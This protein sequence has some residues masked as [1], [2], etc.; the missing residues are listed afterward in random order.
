M[1]GT[2]VGNVFWSNMIIA[3][4]F[5]KL[6]F[7]LDLFFCTLQEACL[8]VKEYVDTLLGPYI[9]NVTSSTK[10]CSEILCSKNGRCVRQENHAEAFLHLNSA[11]FTIKKHNVAPGFILI[12]QMS[13]KDQIK[14][15]QE[16]T[17]Q[18]YD[19]WKGLHCEKKSIHNE[20]FS[21]HFHD[22]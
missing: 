22:I 15:A 12:G 19:G 1:D 8:E 3:D 6:I 4:N 2:L 21:P 7:F 20:V 14:M 9:M 10:I 13:V 18:C 16:F 5:F 11:S 17:C